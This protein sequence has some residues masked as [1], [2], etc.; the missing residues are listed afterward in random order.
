MIRLTRFV[1]A[2]LVSLLWSQPAALS[3][4]PP[5]SEPAA[6]S[7][8]RLSDLQARVIG[9]R[10][11]ESG[12]D[13]L[14]REQRV[15]VTRF[16][17]PSTRRVYY[18]LLLD[19]PRLGRHLDFV[20]HTVFTHADG[21]VFRSFSH[22][23]Y[24][25]AAWTGE[26]HSGYA[27]WE[28]PGRWPASRY[29]VV[30][31]IGGENVASGSFE[32]EGFGQ[33]QSLSP[34]SASGSLRSASGP[35]DR[36]SATANSG[37]VEIRKVSVRA[38]NDSAVKGDV[39]ERGEI[40]IPEGYV[41]VSHRTTVSKAYPAVAS[42]KDRWK[43]SD[44]VTRAPDGK[45]TSVWLEVRAGPAD[46]ALPGVLVPNIFVNAELSVEMR[47]LSEGT[48]S[49]ISS[50]GANSSSGTVDPANTTEQP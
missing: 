39:V 48:S 47:P 23:S 24:I 43:V 31:T 13:P 50:P 4:T 34:G 38:I 9:L 37:A 2:S 14:P 35:S 11:F 21:K 45:V 30:V 36:V 49:L 10:F 46:A 17:Q 32:V 12:R 6:K 40:P 41:Y 25:E 16:A 42:K 27:G 20:I 29:Q 22:D 18:D 19:H 33:A 44:G 7:E 1:L 3:Q 8:P 26:W 15:Y 28:Q 5:G